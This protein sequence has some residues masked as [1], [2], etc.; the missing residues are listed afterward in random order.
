MSSGLRIPIFRVL[1]VT[2]SREAR[3]I[4]IMYISTFFLGGHDD[5]LEHG[6]GRV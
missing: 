3:L 2:N 1:L 5:A 4:L 6:T